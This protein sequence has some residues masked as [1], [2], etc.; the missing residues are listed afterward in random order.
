MYTIEAAVEVRKE[1][2]KLEQNI[3]RKTLPRTQAAR[4]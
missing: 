2:V 1:R 3:H 4:Q